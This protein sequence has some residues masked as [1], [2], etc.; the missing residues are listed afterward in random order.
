MVGAQ[1]P[2]TRY[3][4]ILWF[5]IF[6][7]CGGHQGSRGQGCQIDPDHA[8][9]K[10][11]CGDLRLPADEAGA[12]SRERAERRRRSPFGHTKCPSHSHNGCGA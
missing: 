11:L 1:T 10:V 9:G 4:S 6:V 8:I 5:R 3:R 2:P 7:D 12:G